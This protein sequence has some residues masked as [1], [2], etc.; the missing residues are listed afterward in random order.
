MRLMSDNDWKHIETAHRKHMELTLTREGP[1]ESIE[2]CVSPSEPP[3]ES[4][5][6]VGIVHYKQGRGLER[7]W[8]ATPEEA[9]KHTRILEKL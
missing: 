1:G 3:W 9:R 4:D 8:C 6:L 2:V 5:M 7:K